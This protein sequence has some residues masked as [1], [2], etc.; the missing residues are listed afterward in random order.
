MERM[1]TSTFMLILVT[2]K[3]HKRDFYG[4]HFPNV[5]VVYC[6]IFFGICVTLLRSVQIVIERLMSRVHQ[7]LNN[8]IVSSALTQPLLFSGMLHLFLHSPWLQSPAAKTGL[9]VTR[10]FFLILFKISFGKLCFCCCSC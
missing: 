5:D 10:N 3:S 9:Q 7:I 2:I 8:L 1:P 4:S 6:L